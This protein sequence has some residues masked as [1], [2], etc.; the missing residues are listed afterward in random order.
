MLWIAL[1]ES[2]S[3][4]GFEDKRAKISQ[5]RKIISFWSNLQRPQHFKYELENAA[6][7][8]DM[9]WYPIEKEY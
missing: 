3:K 1:L 4:T 5:R 8:S 7:V 9:S 6:E 2:C